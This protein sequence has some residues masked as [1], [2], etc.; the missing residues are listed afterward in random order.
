MTD[1]SRSVADTP[2]RAR[3]IA[4]LAAAALLLTGCMPAAPDGPA[5]R[6]VSHYSPVVCTGK[7]ITCR[8]KYR[9]DVRP[10]A[11]GDPVRIRLYRAEQQA[12][13]VGDEYPACLPE[14]G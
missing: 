9:I 1:L 6:V 8:H 4:A 10:A 7:P 5:G 13:A 3:I 12:C 11:G 14:E 2:A